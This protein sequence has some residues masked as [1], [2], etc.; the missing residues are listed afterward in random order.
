MPENFF[1]DHNIDPKNKDE[2]WILKRVKALWNEV[3]HDNESFM[4]YKAR[5]AYEDL[6]DYW[7]GRQSIDKYKP[8][9][10]VDPRQK[11]SVLAID[12]TPQNI[13]QK[14]IDI[15]V[16]KVIGR[17]YNVVATPI[18]PL[19]KDEA[20]KY[21]ADIRA[22]IMIREMAKAN[23][24]DPMQF[25]ALRKQDGEPEDLEELEMTMAYGYKYNLAMETEMGIELVLYKN[26]FE[27]ERQMSILDEALYGVGVYKDDVEENGETRVRRCYPGN[28]IVSHCKRSDFSDMRYVGEL[29]DVPLSQLAM[30]FG[31]SELETI[32][33]QAQKDTGVIQVDNHLNRVGR[34]RFNVRVLDIEFKSWNTDSFRYSVNKAG[35]LVVRKHD[36]LSKG[37]DVV[38]DHNGEKYP[39]FRNRTKEVIYKAKWVVGTEFLYDYGLAT[40]M[41]RSKSTGAKVDFSYHIDSPNFHNMTATSKMDQLKPII[42]EYVSTR[43][44]IQNFKARWIPYIVDIDF[45][46]IEDVT[47]GKGGKALSPKEVLDLVWQKFILPN[48]RRDASGANVNYKA[49]DIRA[50]NMSKEY[51]ELVND[52]GRLYVEMREI[53]GLNEI[54]DASSPNPNLLNG[55]ASL[56]VEATNN[57]L[58]PL[59]DS[60]KRLCESVYHGVIR[61]LVHVVKRKQIDGLLPALGS[62]S[63]RFFSLTPD[64]SMHDWGIQLENRPTELEK[65][66]FMQKMKIADANGQI[67][68]EDY[69]IL[70]VCTNLKQAS[71]LLAHRINKRK[72]QAD[73]FAMAQVELNGKTQ[74]DSARVAEEE[75][76]KTAYEAHLHKLAEIDKAKEWDYKIKGLQVDGA[77][78]QKEMDSTT[79]I[80]TEMMKMNGA[81][82]P[83]NTFV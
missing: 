47:L 77:A 24:L 48:R 21:Y 42:D 26:K 82:Q 16:S 54:T 76:R 2:K 23:G 60:D 17:G 65:Q 12:W 46:A 81:E 52:L 25:P 73:E 9:Q 39:R 28:M 27:I 29:R 6:A 79:R 40:D 30:V 13:Q 20:D 33:E 44:K 61:R 64:I 67:N 19:A 5:K 3:E 11:T 14:L 53:I 78:G 43:Y 56:G 41:K 63:M 38:I 45:D 4:F 66:E 58:R 71:A 75:K 51:V 55:V 7:L 22:K 59:M 57:A 80:A 83:E 70:M 49:V 62:N 69:T 34:D 74:Q 36:K 37:N 8:M 32:A 31:G 1:S 15:A 10:G 35:N 50:T 68:P 18:D 72:K